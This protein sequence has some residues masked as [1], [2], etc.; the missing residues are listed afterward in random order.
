MENFSELTWAEKMVWPDITSV[1]AM[2]LMENMITALCIYAAVA[3][4]HNNLIIQ[5]SPAK[6]MYQK[7]T[8]PKICTVQYC[9]L[10]LGRPFLAGHNAILTQ[11][12]MTLSRSS[13]F[14]MSIVILYVSYVRE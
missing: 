12:K 4:V 13:V 5:N 8:L 2:H 11:S 6:H 3:A 14:K 10:L 1:I 7:S 9:I